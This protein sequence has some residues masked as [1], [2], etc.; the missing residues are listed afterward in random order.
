[1][2]TKSITLLF[3]LA[4]LLLGAGFWAS[5]HFTRRSETTVTRA[6]VVTPKGMQETDSENDMERQSSGFESDSFDTFIQLLTSE[7][8]INSITLDFNNDG[9][10][11]EVITVR[12]TG[13]EDFIIVPGLFN[14]ESADYDR[15][16]SIPTS[17]SRIRTFSISGMDL[18]GDHRNALIYQGVDDEENYVMSL[19]LWE[20]F[21]SEEDSFNGTLM[22]I[23]NF[24]SD[25]TIFIQQVER[26]DS[27]QLS[28]SKGESF[29][30]WVY[31]SEK[32]ADENG[33]MV[34]G[35]NQIQKEYKWNAS[36]RQYELFNEIKVTAGR[37]AA[38]ELSRIQ[39]G[40]VETFAA[41]LD[42][43]WYKTSNEDNNIRYLYFD[44]DKKEII[45]LLSDSQEVYEWDDSKLRH[46]G[47][48]L[49]TVNSDITNL[50]RRFDILL[51]SID[52][53]KVTLYDSIGL[54]IT[55]SSVWDGQYKKLGIQSSFE[56]TEGE[57]KNQFEKELESAA[58][59]TSED[60]NNTLSM[61]DHRYTFTF[62][63]LQAEEGIYS[64]IRIGSYN[65]I[66]LRATSFNSIL[67]QTYALDFGTRTIT[68]TVKK[69]TVEKT[70]TDYDTIIFSPVKITPTDCFATD[71]RVYTFTKNKE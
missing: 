26:S 58:L 23:G 4:A 21:G 71:G 7:T 3:F 19:F 9:Y 69:Q 48:Y 25:G 32:Q 36:S 49:Y 66:Q 35:P 40:T 62:E 34:P 12:R 17:I 31:E 30:V 63:N 64:M 68:E 44:Y 51:T 61:Q 57:E 14:P 38:N 65:V 56:E 60:G 10:D 28:L 5:K 6:K 18:T 43:L 45:L 11:D 37:L 27:Y 54:A 55:Y 52:E 20:S 46:N 16:A 70:V 15:L 41:F 33:N 50:Q 24:V 39:D 59:W 8:L 13:S 1:M 22:N 29:S 47:I 2:K 67:N 42:G 53:I